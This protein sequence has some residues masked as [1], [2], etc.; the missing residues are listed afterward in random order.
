[1]ATVRH[2]PTATA[3]SCDDEAATAASAVCGGKHP[4][5]RRVNESPTSAC[6]GV[7]P[8]SGAAAVQGVAQR[9]DKNRA[10]YSR[11]NGT[12]RH[13]ARQSKLREHHL[14][15]AGGCPAVPNNSRPPRSP[16]PQSGCPAEPPARASCCTSTPPR[17]SCRVLGARRIPDPPRGI[18]AACQKTR[19][20]ASCGAARNTSLDPQPSSG[21]LSHR[22]PRGRSS[23]AAAA[24]LGG[25]VGP[26][27]FQAG[28]SETRKRGGA[29]ASR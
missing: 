26:P 27:R 21:R 25:S 3:E 15:Q 10:S 18:D 13:E 1:M 8:G 14:P 6:S 24:R 4:A 19:R 9:G 29:G 22:R 16:R 2:M 28:N 12:A 20:P 7:Q 5:A 23:L 11:P 17:Y